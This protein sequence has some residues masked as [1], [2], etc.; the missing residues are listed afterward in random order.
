M[1]SQPTSI[2]APRVPLVQANTNIM[3][4]EWYRYL[5]ENYTLVGSTGS[6]SL[7]YKTDVQDAAHGLDALMSLRPV[8]F[9]MRSDPSKVVGGFI[10]EEVDAAGLT[11]FV[12]YDN[13]GPDRLYYDRMISLA[14]KAIQDQQVIIEELR[15]R[16]KNLEEKE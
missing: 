6:S 14:V 16:V 1:P 11:E 13:K 5:F 10:A 4:R 2:P 15:A 3:S 8:T 7:K 9:R 12:I